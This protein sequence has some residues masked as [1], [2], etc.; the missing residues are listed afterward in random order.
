MTLFNLIKHKTGQA[1]VEFALIVP[2]LLLIL[3]GIIDFSRMYY[4]YALINNTNREALRSMAVGTS[5]SLVGDKIKNSLEPVVG[6]TSV[7]I[8]EGTDNSGNAC[9]KIVLTNTTKLQAFITPPYKSTLTAG[10]D[11]SLTIIYKYEFITPMKLFFNGG[12]TLQSRY[13]TRLETVPK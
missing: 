12:V 6:G 11:I 7:V 3:F 8:S 13:Y 1:I 5:V 10:S 4:Q 9:T 2:I